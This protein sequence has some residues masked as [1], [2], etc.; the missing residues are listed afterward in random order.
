MRL[1]VSRAPLVGF[2][3][4]RH[5][6]ILHLVPFLLVSVA[7]IDAVPSVARLDAESIRRERALIL[8]RI[9]NQNYRVTT[10]SCGCYRSKSPLWARFIS[11]LTYLAFLF[12]PSLVFP[13]YTPTLDHPLPLVLSIVYP[14]PRRPRTSLEACSSRT[15]RPSI[16]LG[17]LPI[18]SS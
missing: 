4:S 10:L 18:V 11:G 15:S 8:G 17:D 7:P 9:W 13:L 3:L 14:D 2:L 16:F 12:L 6:R 5:F 1:H